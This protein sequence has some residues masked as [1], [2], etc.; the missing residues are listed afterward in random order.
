MR[1]RA[2]AAALVFP[3]GLLAACGGGDDSGL[4][5]RDDESSDTTEADS[6]DTTDEGS[7]DT[8]EEDSSD[9][10][11]EGSSDTTEEGSSDSIDVGDE[12]EVREQAINAF[13]ELGLSEEDATCLIDAIGVDQLVDI[14]LGSGGDISNVDPEQIQVIIDA[15]GECDIDPTVLTGGG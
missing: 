11:A 12:D 13:V 5:N 9:T 3:L 6:S 15:I 8:T 4:T 7:S 10:T 14:G 2:L 1:F